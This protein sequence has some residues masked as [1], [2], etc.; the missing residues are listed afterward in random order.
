MSAESGGQAPGRDVL[1]LFLLGAAVLLSGLGLRDPWAPDEPR[2]ALIARDMLISGDW[3]IPRVGGDL[4]PDKPPLFMWLVAA[5]TW[6]TG[7]LR[8]GF[9]LPSMIASLGVLWLVFD[10]A[11]R[12]WDRD[13]AVAAG[14]VLLTTLQFPL[15]AHSA[16][17]DAT[18]CFWTTLSLYGLLRHLLLGPA[19]G[20]YLAG[21][22]AAGLGVITK[23]VGILPLLVLLPWAWA[24]RRRWLTAPAGPRW[25]W[26]AGP[27]AMLAAIGL[28][29]APMLLHTWNSLDPDLAAY[30]DNILMKQTMERYAR[31]WGHIQPPWYFLTHVIPLL[32]LPTVVLVPWLW[33]HWRASFRGASAPV[34]LL[35]GWILLV[36]LF[37]SA[38]PGKRGVYLLP[39]V[40]AF[41]LAVAP[42]ARTLSTRAGVRGLAL[43]FVLL[44]T[45]I[46]ALL[47][48]RPPAR[49]IE[50]A[51]ASASTLR[52][53]F[54]AWAAYGVVVMAICRLQRASAGVVAMMAGLMIGYGA[55]VFPAAN[56]L[57]SGS[58]IPRAAEALLGPGETLGLVRWKEQ[59]L[60]HARRPLVHFGYRRSVEAE[61]MADALAWLGQQPG[62]A[63]VL[64][65]SDLEPCF[66]PGR[67]RPLGGAHRQDWFLVR[68][69]ALTG[70]CRAP[71]SP[72]YQR[73][74]RP[75]TRYRLPR[76]GQAIIDSARG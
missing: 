68:A 11:R 28:W 3:L 8:I 16:Q 57:R 38:T 59:F 40:P 51:G 27:L 58:S 17:I 66:D 71:A 50:Q 61:E 63:L 31:S 9:L 65:G 39:A 20:W 52:I 30:R 75:A 41:A 15:Q 1:L 19:W 49:L 53:L 29:L 54:A 5:G 22:A 43:A 26:F 56:D 69:D 13:T 7:S 44:L 67:A 6:L 42:W 10:L 35:L 12:L 14:L 73:E 32:W 45:G 48:I 18:L 46:C 37:F 24:R 62:R 47:A 36:L 2:F 21:W 60:L 72:V 4:Y 70:S 23:G 34:F 55:V 76:G 33:T 74:Y 25:L 64:R